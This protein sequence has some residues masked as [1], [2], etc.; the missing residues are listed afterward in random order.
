MKEIIQKDFEIYFGSEVLE[1]LAEILITKGYS[2]IFV[3]VDSQTKKHCWPILSPYLVNYELLEIE[4]GEKNKN[5]ENASIIWTKLQT[6]KADKKAVLINLG[7]GVVSDLGGFVAAT[8]KRGIDFINIP[9]SLLGMVDASIGGK[10]GIDLNELKNAVG[11]IQNPKY[12]FIDPNFLKTLPEIE[13]RNGLAEVCKHALIDDKPLFEKLQKISLLDNLDSLLF[14]SLKIKVKIVKKDPF[15]KDTRKTLNFGH[16]IGHAIETYSLKNDS[17]PIK[18]GEAIAIGMIC[19]AYISASIQ[20]LSQEELRKI[21]SYF[22]ER[23]LKYKGKLPVKEL[24]EY[25]KNDKK[26]EEGFINFTL[27]KKIG[28][29]KIN[30]TCHEDLIIKSLEYYQNL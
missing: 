11:L 12:I 15:E 14:Q 10:L 1:K 17:L 22:S 21:S 8:Y 9:T 27:L 29:A 3:L 13:K 5:L 25:M 30:A 20:G 16:T 6:Y 7:G 19:E 26:N 2:K 23:F 18:H 4:A 24:I 28:K